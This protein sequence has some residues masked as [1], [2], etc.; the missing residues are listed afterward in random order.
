MEYV[1]TPY[2]SPVEP[3]AWWRGAFTD[4]EL[5]VL[6]NMARNATIKAQIGGGGSGALN[7]K[8]RRS[9]INWVGNGPDTSWIFRKLGHVAASLNAQFFRF[10]LTGFGEQLQFTNYDQ[11]ELGM[12]GW[13]QDY[14]GQGPSRKLSLVVQLSDPSDYEGGELQIKTGADDHVVLKE[15]GL[16]VAF[17]SYTLHQVTPVT[18]GNRQSLVA[19]VSG[20]EFK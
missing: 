15:R 10:D 5:N 7:N 13:H 12:Y 19:W 16:I 4:D 18:K 20:P 14:G 17:A 1:L 3:Y 11:S 9:S 2:A 8:V 6:Q